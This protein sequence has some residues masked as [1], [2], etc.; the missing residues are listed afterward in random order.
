MRKIRTRE[1]EE[2]IKKRN[3]WIIG[4]ILVFIMIGSG[5]GIMV[6]SFGKNTNSRNA[7]QYNGFEFFSNQGF[8]VTNISNNFFVFRYLPNETGFNSKITN[9]KDIRNYFD[10]P[11][12]VYS[13]NDEA[14]SIVFLNMNKVALRIQDACPLNETCEGNVPIKDCTNNFII[15]KESNTTNINQSQNCVFIT[16]PKS[17]LVKTTEEFFYQLLGIK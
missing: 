2:R 6:N 15:I 14:K 10:E 12:Y 7:I 5:F 1:E 9:L 8:W 11:L 13:K 17:K 16:A 3:Q 4:G